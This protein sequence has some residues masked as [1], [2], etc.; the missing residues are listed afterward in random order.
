MRA[1]RKAQSDTEKAL[2]WNF[3]SQKKIFACSS[4]AMVPSYGRREDETRAEKWVGRRGR[5]ERSEVNVDRAVPGARKRYRLTR[6]ANCIIERT[7]QLPDLAP[8]GAPQGPRITARADH[9]GQQ[10]PPSVGL[11]QPS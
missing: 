3:D 10:A 11:S 2:S 1:Q 4:T 6:S 5:L 8:E 9:D 7:D